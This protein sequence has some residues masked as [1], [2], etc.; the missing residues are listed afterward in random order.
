[1]RKFGL[2]ILLA[3]LS[4]HAPAQELRNCKTRACRSFKELLAG[5]DPLVMKSDRVCFYDGKFPF[6]GEGGS[7][8]QFFLLSTKGQTAWETFDNTA[9]AYIY[10]PLVSI[11]IADG[12]PS[13]YTYY[14]PDKDWTPGMCAYLGDGTKVGRLQ[15]YSES[16]DE[17]VFAELRFGLSKD[18]NGNNTWLGCTVTT[19][20]KSTWRFKSHQES[21][22]LPHYAEDYPGRCFLIP[23]QSARR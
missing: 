2:L 18:K 17:I 6:E 19:I 20:R 12:Q 23:K 21:E 16:D 11:A 15:P 4:A 1:M 14:A 13:Q 8:D 10:P 5:K 9:K 3:L 22:L 7:P